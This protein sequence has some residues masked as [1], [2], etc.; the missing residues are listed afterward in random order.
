MIPRYLISIRNIPWTVSHSQLEGYFSKFGSVRTAKVIFDKYGI[1]TG[2]G[3][4]EFYDKVV[5]TSVL[6]KD[7]V[8]DDGKLSIT[9][10]L[11]YLHEDPVKEFVEPHILN[12]DT[13]R[14]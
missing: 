5:V 12:A 13:Y 4:V 3:F 7:H 6:K 8:L 10:G 1:S 14:Q 9:K 11:Q 2:Y